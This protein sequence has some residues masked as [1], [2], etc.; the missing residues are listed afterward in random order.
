MEKKIEKITK[1]ITEEVVSYVAIDG[2]KFT[3]EE[4][5]RTYDGTCRAVLMARFRQIPKRINSGFWKGVNTGCEDNTIIF[6]KLDKEVKD[7]ILQLLKAYEGRV[8]PPFEKRLMEYEDG[9][10][11]ALEVNVYSN[12]GI[13]SFDFFSI[14]GTKEEVIKA[15]EEQWESMQY[16]ENRLK[17]CEH[18]VDEEGHDSYARYADTEM[19][20]LGLK[21]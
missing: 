6:L 19:T 10:E 3:T 16:Q 9:T 7:L 8:Y 2:T 21:K 12:Q 13:P 14:V 15:I 4:E 20:F 1:T 11:V 17:R 5:C 18:S